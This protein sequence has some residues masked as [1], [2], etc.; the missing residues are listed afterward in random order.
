[1]SSTNPTGG[2]SAWTLQKGTTP[3]S[4]S[5]NQV[6]CASSSLCIAS[7]SNGEI[8]E[9]NNPTGGAGA[10]TSTEWVDGTKGLSGVSC[11]SESLC[12]VTDEA[13]LIGIPARTLSVSVAGMGHGHVTSTPIACPFGCT[14]SGPACPRNCGGLSFNAFTPQR[15]SGISCIENGWFG[16]AGWGTCSLSFPAQNTVTLTATPDPGSTFMGWGGDCSGGASCAVSMSSDRSI[17]A[18]FTASANSTIQSTSNP[19]RLTGVAESAKRWREGSAFAQISVNRQ[20]LPVGTTFS[21][22]LDEPASVAFKFTKSISGRKVR[23]RCVAH[24]K[25]NTKKRRCTRITAADTLT[26]SAHTGVNKMH[27]EGLISKHKKLEPGSYALTLTATAS[28]KH[29]TP[30]TLHFTIANG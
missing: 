4:N 25:K 2:A 27:F 30:S 15:L 13:L 17:S 24:A 22:G 9:S 12:F 19:P 28:G 8:A 16:E 1:M 10:W 26:L 18:T 7:A 23:K 14:Y 20:K 29:S 3:S 5:F 21:F 11:A 6:A